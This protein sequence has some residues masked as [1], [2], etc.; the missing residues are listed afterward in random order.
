M[1]ITFN[2]LPEAVS[3][4]A[5]EIGE[6]KRLLT[7]K[8][9]EPQPEPEQ[10][11][12]VQQAAEFLKLSVPTLYTYVQ[13]AQIPVCKRHKRLYFSKSELLS[14]IKAGR[15]KTILEASIEADNY[16]KHTSK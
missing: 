4:L 5:D 14:W 15:K 8:A 12:T 11:L 13:R 7:Q 10:L 1:E 6:I 3:S 9:S 16:L 2:N